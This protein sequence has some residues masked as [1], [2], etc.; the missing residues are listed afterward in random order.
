MVV[1]YTNICQPTLPHQTN[2]RY[3]NLAMKRVPKNEDKVIFGKGIFYFGG[4][5][6]RGQVL[7]YDSFLLKRFDVRNMPELWGYP[8]F[9]PFGFHEQTTSGASSL[10]FPWNSGSQV[11]WQVYPE[12]NQSNNNQFLAAATGTISAIDGL[13]VGWELLTTG[14]YVTNADWLSR[15]YE[16]MSC[17][18]FQRW[19][20]LCS[21]IELKRSPLGPSPCCIYFQSFWAW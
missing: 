2:A 9:P 6:G 17:F 19:F 14:S 3:S 13:K 12:G 21:A 18:K 16:N 11:E 10:L 15:N 20:G 5:R 7:V 8:G 1:S 4:N